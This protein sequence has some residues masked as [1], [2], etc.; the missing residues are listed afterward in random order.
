MS[1]TSIGF[2]KKK[3]ARNEEEKGNL[4]QNEQKT[5]TCCHSSTYLSSNHQYL[6]SGTNHTQSQNYV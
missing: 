2:K 1:D 6:V 4:S 5:S 3:T